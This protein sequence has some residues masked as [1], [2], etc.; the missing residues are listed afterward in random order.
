MASQREPDDEAIQDDELQY[1]HGPMTMEELDDK[2]G[3]DEDTPR[4]RNHSK[5]PPFSE[6]LVSLFNPLNDNKKRPTGPKV[7]AKKGPGS[8]TVSPHEQRRNIIQQFILRWRS[9]VGNDFYP[10]LRLILPEKDRDRPMYGLKE[11]AIG[12]LIVKMLKINANGDD[13]QSLLNWK[14][15]GQTTASRMAGD[16]AGRCFEVLSKRAMRQD[17]GD[18]RIAE[19]NELLDRLSA[20]SKEEDQLP[21]FS[22]FYNRM[23]ADELLWLIRIILRQMKV[24]ASEKTILEMW[25]PDG[26]ILFNVSSS[27]RRVCWDLWDPSIRLDDDRR[28]I[29]LMSC[30]QPQLAQFSQHSIQKMIER[31]GC[32]SDNPEFWIE[33]KLDGERMQ[34][35]MKPDP[36]VKGGRKFAF[37]SRKGKD[38]TYLY[39]SSLEDQNSSLTRFLKDAFDP[40]VESIILDGEMITWDPVTRSMVGFGTLKTAAIS[41]QRNPYGETGHRPLF[42]IFDCL[43]INDKDITGFMLQDRR[44]ALERVVKN[45]DMRLE[46]HK[47]Q[48]AATAA[49][50]ETEL[51]K[52]IEEA[53]EGLVLKNPRSVY[54]LNSRNDDWMKV[55]PEYMTE[56]GESLDCVVIGG[57]YG[58]GHRGG[59]L[60][61][62]LCGLRVDD[63]AIKAGAD[64]MKCLSFFKVGGGFRAEDYAKVHHKT[65]GKWRKWDRNNPPRDL[66][67]L[68]GNDNQQFERPDE[69]IK[70][71]DSVVLEVKAASVAASDH[72]GYQYSLRFPRFKKLRDDKSWKEALSTY[73]FVELKSRVEEESKNKALKIDTSR[74]ASKRLKKEVLIAGNN[75]KIRTP[76]AGPQTKAFEGLSFWVMT[77]KEDQPKKTKAEMEQIIKSNGGKIVQSSTATDSV[78]CIGDKRVVKVASLIKSGETNIV[79][80][81]WVLDA[82]KQVEIDGA[83]RQRFLIPSEPAHMY[84]MLEEVRE[85]IEGAVDDY[86][87]SYARDVNVDDLRRLMED[88]IHPKDSEFSATEFLSELEERGKGFGEVPGSM[89][90]RC[91]ARF[92]PANDETSGIDLEIAKNQFL[93]AGG[94][95]AGDDE[96][97]SITHYIV[98]STDSKLV[99]DLRKSISRGSLRIPR[100]VSLSWL[101]D[102]W[103]EKTVLDEEQYAIV[104]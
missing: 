6:L 37:W 84:H 98:T 95:I 48:V 1:G 87:D 22:Q 92:V 28:G 21:I 100:I 33:E 97:D 17:F 35:H 25:H 43:Y 32:T 102:S 44:E 13:A 80:P 9:Q 66:I 94:T 23:N 104:V 85:H 34:L 15:P 57:Y 11:K 16:F 93:F 78:I 52:V 89:F 36:N 86:G 27:L 88:M 12:K 61:S 4:P 31:M 46:I 65:E 77:G 45:V 63:N 90:R 5:T 62:F 38:Y 60:S 76:Y 81:A 14:L 101:S 3:G 75:T 20:V 53:S 71:C 70:P 40:G 54:R 49:E 19:V 79:K 69:W 83:E 42:R 26:E 29:E 82:L 7:V 51:R 50:V 72:Y 2:Y 41:E 91:V 74:R 55:K 68:G 103:K 64:P 8:K 24:G 96:D 67:V 73:E 39:G 18:M 30:F 10:A 47:Y 99:R 56:F 59:M 58:S